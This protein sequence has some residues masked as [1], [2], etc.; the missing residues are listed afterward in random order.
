MLCCDGHSLAAGAEYWSEPG[1][2]GRADVSTDVDPAGSEDPHEEVELQIV[3]ARYAWAHRVMADAVVR[4][5]RRLTASDR[6]DRVLTSRW[7]GIP[8][9]LAVMW[10]VFEATTTIAAPLQD[11]VQALFDGPVT[12]G[13]SAVLA[14]VHAPDW[15][16]G[17]VQDGLVSGVGQMLSF[18]PLMA[19]M[20]LLLAVLEDS[21]YMARAPFVV[22]RLMRVIGLPGKAFLP[23]IVGFGCNVPAIAGTRILRNPRQRLLL[24]L[25]IPFVS[26]SAR[27]TVYVLLAGIFFGDEAGTMVFA[28]YVLSIVLVI[29]MGLLLR[30]LVFRDLTDEAL[31]LELPPYRRPT[32]RVMGV[33]TWQKLR[34]FLRT[35]SGIIVATVTAV[36]LLCSSRW[37][38]CSPCSC[39]R[40]GY[41][42][43]QCVASG[44]R[45]DRARGR[46][47]PGR[48]RRAG[49]GRPGRGGGDGRVLG[50]QGSAHGR[51]PGQRL[52]ERRLRLVLVRGRGRAGLRRVL[53]GRPPGAA[54]DRCTPPGPPPD[55]RAGSTQ[56]RRCAACVELAQRGCPARLHGLRIAHRGE[57]GPLGSRHPGDNRAARL[58]SAGAGRRAVADGGDERGWTRVCVRVGSASLVVSGDPARDGEATDL[59]RKADELIAAGVGRSRSR[60]GW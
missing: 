20:F 10:A 33:Q 17:L 41:W 12:A 30:R 44:A 42:S 2:S 27:L 43:R 57:E 28:M 19:I 46:H 40:S 1:V 22:D 9:F 3:E 37:R 23:I 59:R 24:G 52:L 49:R 18:T 29:G 54:G 21:G 39:S 45:R 60:I 38:G 32:L 36:W 7:F 26:C 15:L 6:V 47:E 14:L 11:A 13:A 55:A 58:P 34:A 5:G 16:A 31:M 4:G 51:R 50:P 25:L 35:A 8:L 48:G 53:V 56:R